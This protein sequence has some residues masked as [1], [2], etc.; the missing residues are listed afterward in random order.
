LV[1]FDVE[2]AHLFAKELGLTLEFVPIKRGELAKQLDSNYC[3]V[4]MSGLVK[5]I[6]RVEQMDFSR[7]YLSETV[8]FVVKDHY[9]DEFTSAEARAKIK[10]IRIADA[11]NRNPDYMHLVQ[12]YFP[13]AEFVPIQSI[14]EFFTDKQDR[15]DAILGSA[16][17]G[18]AWSLLY[19]EYSV[20]L[21]RPNLMQLPLAYAVS[22]R[23]PEFIKLV[24]A[25]VEMKKN[26]G[27]IDTLYDY[28]VL[29]KNAVPAKPRW[30]IIRNVLN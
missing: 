7:S 27:T 12:H 25:W 21:P 13:Q 30:S 14:E 2:M 24:N 5:T 8:A 20:A 6:R 9:R 15:F 10:S 26:D 11:S 4:I 17:R 18:S 28:W 22:Y 29:G 16:E 23:Y 1:G 3:D 19:P